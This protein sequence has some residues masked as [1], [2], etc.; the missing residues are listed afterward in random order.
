MTAP[1]VPHAQGA[2]D[3]PGS[4]VP[5]GRNRD[6]RRLWIGGVISGIGTEVT[7]I[8]FP[9]LV[10]AVTGSA[11]YA[12]L[13]Q[14]GELAA[15][16]AITLPA[17]LIA[18]RF[19]RRRLLIFSDLARAVLLGALTVCVVL[20]WVQLGLVIA[21]AMVVAVFDAV[22]GPAQ[23]AALKEVVPPSQ[24]AEAAAR[25]EARLRASR[26]LG[27]A[28]GGWLFSLGRWVPFVGDTV[29]YL[30]SGLLLRRIEKPLDAP[31]EKPETIRLSD[32][33]AGFRLILGNPFLRVMAVIS[34][35][36]TFTLAAFG[37]LFITGLEKQN[38]GSTVIGLALTAYS[39]AGLLG[40]LAAPRVLRVC[41]PRL[42]IIVTAWLIP[43]VMLSLA[44]VPAVP[45][46]IAVACLLY[47]CIPSLGSMS[48]AYLIAITPSNL[49]GRVSAAV[50]FLG[51]ALSPIA[52][53]AFGYVFDAAGRT[54]AFAGMAI[55]GLLTAIPSLSRPIRTLTASERQ[56]DNDD[57]GG[58]TT[59]PQ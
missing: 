58:T 34:M 38:A 36:M 45:F 4:E 33:L 46:A 11:A 24:L 20:G 35:G 47:F 43:A 41:P 48:R 18:D 7:Q 51:L 54:W 31:D 22:F 19:R 50:M 53:A 14:S 55:S 13:L 29:S 23:D 15:Y 5:L 26:L 59:A 12:G 28:L 42:V 17:G 32:T 21:I 1:G 40:A 37:L 56:N 52:P 39:T 2:T 9:L 44:V 10:L 8:G 3:A 16:A 49:Q 30:V 57:N 25:D 6:F 27:P